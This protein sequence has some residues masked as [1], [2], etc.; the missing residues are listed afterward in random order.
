MTVWENLKES[1]VSG[2]NITNKHLVSEL[3]VSDCDKETEDKRK[4]SSN[5]TPTTPFLHLSVWID[6]KFLSFKFTEVT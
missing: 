5:V 3:W 2:V 1:K 4:K 6:L